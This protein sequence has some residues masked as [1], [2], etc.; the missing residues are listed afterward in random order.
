MSGTMGAIEVGPLVIKPPIGLD[1][2]DCS[3]SYTTSGKI[4]LV[5]FG[6][7]WGLV[8]SPAWSHDDG[9]IDLLVETWGQLPYQEAY[10]GMTADGYMNAVRGMVAEIVAAARVSVN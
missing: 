4:A 6:D 2:L 5:H 10:V 9:T 1:F 7:D 8:V 3:V